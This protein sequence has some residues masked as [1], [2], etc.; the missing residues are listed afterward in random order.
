MIALDL[1]NKR[2]DDLWEVFS[3]ADIDMVQ[4][5]KVPSILHSLL[6]EASDAV[7]RKFAEH[8]DWIK[9]CMELFWKDHAIDHPVIRKKDITHNR[10]LIFYIEKVLFP[11]DP[12]WR[13]DRRIEPIFDLDYSDAFVL[14]A[15][16][17]LHDYGKG[18]FLLIIPELADDSVRS[19]FKRAKAVTNLGDESYS[20]LEDYHS[21]VISRFLK[22]FVVYNNDADR[23]Q[24]ALSE[25]YCEEEGTP[26]LKPLFRDLGPNFPF[27]FKKKEPI[28]DA[29]E[30][31]RRVF[32]I[33]WEVANIEGK[34]QELLQ[35]IRIV[36][37]SH[38][39]YQP[40][41]DEIVDF[42]DQ[43]P[44]TADH[45][46][47]RRIAAL[48]R[49]GDN[50]DLTRER[51]E[52]NGI[53]PNEF[54]DF[55]D[56][57]GN[58]AP[59]PGFRK[60]FK[61]WLTFALVRGVDVEHEV[62]TELTPQ[63]AREITAKVVLTY[64]RFPNIQKHLLALRQNV[65]K[66]F[67]SLNYLE[68]LGRVTKK[69]RIVKLQ[70]LY[71][72]TVGAN[73]VKLPTEARLESLFGSA[74][75]NRS[76]GTANPYSLVDPGQMTPPCSL[77]FS[78]LAGV[79]ELPANQKLLYVIRFVRT[80]GR[81]KCEEIASEL[82]LPELEK[83]YQ[84]DEVKLPDSILEVGEDDHIVEIVPAAQIKVSK[85][86]GAMDEHPALLRQKIREVERLGHLLPFSRKELNV[87]QTG[88]PGLDKIL[89]VSG[90][91]SAQV[92][93]IRH[94]RNILVI[95]G[96]GSG[97][98]T[99][100]AQMLNWNL[101]NG[102]Y[103]L[104]LTFEE[105]RSML[106]TTYEENF[107]WR[108]ATA[109]IK[110][111]RLSAS[112]RLENVLD[113]IYR[114]IE[115]EQPE[116]VAIDSLSRLRW[117]P[118]PE[119][120]ENLWRGAD[121]LFRALQI[122]GISSI[123]SLEERD[124][125]PP[126]EEY[127]ADGVIHLDQKDEKRELLI[128]KLRGQDY[129]RGRH[130]F[131]I[132]DRWTSSRSLASGGDDQE[133]W[134]LQPGLNVYPNEQ[135]YAALAERSDDKPGEEEEECI[136]T[137]VRNLN[138]LL[139]GGEHGGYRRGN[140]IL[141]LGSPG[142][143]KTLFGLHFLKSAKF[144][145]GDQGQG[146][147]PVLWLSFEGPLRLLRR[148]VA[149]FDPEVGFVNLLERQEFIFLYVPLALISPEKVLFLVDEL[150][151]TR[152]IHRLVVDSVSEIEEAF[153][154]KKLRFRRFMMTFI[155][156]VSRTRT[157]GRPTSEEA[158]T[159]FLYRVPG[160]FDTAKESESEISTLVDTIIS[161]KTFDMKN[162][163]RRGLYVLKSRGREQQSKL[164]T[165]DI[166]SKSGITISYK[167]WEM[168]GLLSGQTGTIHEPEVFLKYFY[169]N[170][171]ES[172][173]NR[174]LV[175]EFERRY[176]KKGRFTEVRKPA[177]YSE[178]WSFRGH[179]GAGHANIRVVSITRYMVEAFRELDRLHEL[180]V[181]FPETVKRQI[182]EDVRWSRYAIDGD[183]Y[184]SI[185][186]YTDMGFLIA[187]RDL[188]LRLLTSLEGRLEESPEG[189]LRD[190]IYLDTTE[191]GRL[192]E[193]TKAPRA[194]LDKA[195][196]VEVGK[197]IAWRTLKKVSDQIGTVYAGPPYLFAL[198][199][200]YNSTDFMAFFFEVLWTM[201]GDVYHFP[202]FKGSTQE[203]DSFYKMH[204]F[205]NRHLW[206]RLV[207]ILKETRKE[208]SRARIFSVQEAAE[209]V[210]KLYELLSDAAEKIRRRRGELAPEIERLITATNSAERA[211]DPQKA[212]GVEEEKRAMVDGAIDLIEVL[213]L[214]N[215]LFSIDDSDV[216]TL[217]NSFGLKALGF[218]YDLVF[219]SGG[220]IPNPHNGDF[221]HE[222]VFSRSWY[223]QIQG[224]REKL[225]KEYLT[226][227]VEEL[228]SVK[229]E[230]KRQLARDASK[231]ADE[232]LEVRPVP[233][234]SWSGRKRSCTSETVWCVSVVKEA[235][236]PEIGWIFI[237]TLT[238]KDWG[239]KRAR[240]RRG[241]PFR[242]E[243]MKSMQR[244]DPTAYA[245]LQEIMI[246]KQQ[247]DLIYE[248][249]QRL[250]ATY[251]NDEKKK[252]RDA[253][254]DFFAGRYHCRD[255][256]DVLRSLREHEQQ[257]RID[258]FEEL[259]D[260]EIQE[261]SIEQ[262]PN[263]NDRI[264]ELPD[265]EQ[266]PG[267]DGAPELA[268]RSKISAHRPLFH[269]IE[270]VLHGELVKL[271]S[272][273]GRRE[274]FTRFTGEGH[275]GKRDEE[276]AE[277]LRKERAKEKP[278]GRKRGFLWYALKRMEDRLIFD[279][280]TRVSPDLEWHLA[281][282]LQSNEDGTAVDA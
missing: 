248:A 36:S 223:S 169:E 216:V 166:D 80:Y 128:D 133:P 93:G 56:S 225:K 18:Q 153:G 101:E 276:I 140:T 115:T 170:P 54:K 255:V 230:E 176:A 148:S 116:I 135:Y 187:R 268:Q 237:D 163:I 134:P 245:M 265:F 266:H 196:A 209:G 1:N 146:S 97:K 139:P 104:M 272:P 88:I 233:Y 142:A 231:Y 99:L 277:G 74:E 219:D 61:K 191:G 208:S 220:S 35:T 4:A 9:K 28:Q 69:K 259:L 125:G 145:E 232:L 251:R 150:V 76:E 206:R 246:N 6:H 203:R 162:E 38:K 96:P 180:Q 204:I 3:T 167:G 197:E 50:L 200:L 185:P 213:V 37:R 228:V 264:S 108:N 239:E 184:D 19:D 98:T 258:I 109:F 33:L 244:H 16:A 41:G 175:E 122:R 31:Q 13:Q 29:W 64:Y 274:W 40:E 222:A 78:P 85:L 241:F 68:A 107:G 178:F 121:A 84:K 260:K 229:K 130:A 81:K 71:A 70:L 53:L 82:P 256:G 235:L 252:A 72:V 141:V 227:F 182:K 190:L 234:S 273:Q 149:S 165:M 157:Q 48:L 123:S 100:L 250:L 263:P 49:L 129:A 271:F 120:N 262:A 24:S 201:G 66:D 156:A 79:P 236:S 198:P 238:S 52:E 92:A 212:A 168:E 20:R 147:R 242:F 243:E 117:D 51:L 217:G 254:K 136:D 21:L 32:Q 77:R 224:A 26:R 43:I 186:V 86:L 281:Q 119:R 194:S 257:W 144:E 105:L 202:S 193:P 210:S 188:A 8:I 27:S 58:E 270:R 131:E 59:Y 207:E 161:I 240:K 152:N 126:E 132:L 118:R 189:D 63:G 106:A 154:G 102:R 2:H 247:K 267:K 127:R 155:D 164:Q 160:F 12:D 103:V 199:D 215:N 110:N 137:G 5:G 280:L 221:N 10:R 89:S 151:R 95:G 7:N 65:E 23:L 174:E 44:D 173:I 91:T 113:K 42:Y 261:G 15:A 114:A 47:L 179:Y 39:P 253:M 83:L 111:I 17:Y 205:Q 159:M 214:G 124:S 57:D 158:T 90:S 22:F 192:T 211:P 55:L 73:E 143:G 249:E 279:L 14:L 275:V 195:M 75:M 87:L 181:F 25:F 34:G 138:A 183:K 177:I 278:P 45:D 11:V 46:H 112:D 172:E 94:A 282:K 60:L 171:A 67:F 226:S 269:R 62:A 218:F 30:A